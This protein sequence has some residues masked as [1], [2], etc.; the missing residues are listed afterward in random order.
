MLSVLLNTHYLRKAFRYSYSK[1]FPQYYI[2]Q[3]I[4]TCFYFSLFPY[5]QDIVSLVEDMILATDVSR[6][7]EFMTQFEELI[8]SERLLDLGI[9]EE[10]RFVLQVSTL[11]INCLFQFLYRQLKLVHVHTAMT[12]QGANI[13][14]DCLMNT[15]FG[16]KQ[17]AS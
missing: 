17:I 15:V 6:N 14:V 5:S 9:Q 4:N 1:L 7:K 16:C 10:R 12:F 11:H 3:C 8:L 2:M 13:N